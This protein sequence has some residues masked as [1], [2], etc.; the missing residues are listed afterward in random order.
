MNT[1]SGA[2]KIGNGKTLTIDGTFD[3]STAGLS[4]SIACATASSCYYG[5]TVGS[6]ATATPTL[7]IDGLT[8]SQLDTNG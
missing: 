2:L 7:N 1:A 5:I 6:S 3:A 8:I 4:R